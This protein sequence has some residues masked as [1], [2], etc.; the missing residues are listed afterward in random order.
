[1]TQETLTKITQL[2]SLAWTFP[3]LALCFLV[4]FEIHRPAHNACFNPLRKN[5]QMCWILYGLLFAFVGKVVESAWWFIPWT[6]NY[7]DHPRWA[8]FNDLGVYINIVFR[9]GFFTVAAYC[10]LRAF[11]PPK[12]DN[13]SLCFV[14]WVLITS[15]VM[16]Q[17]YMLALL[18]IKPIK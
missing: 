6:L 10:H 2:Q 14:H 7:I 15:F 12:K 16:G 5:T 8:E 3:L 1:M 18:D 9:Q 17:V 4:L 13:G 11:I